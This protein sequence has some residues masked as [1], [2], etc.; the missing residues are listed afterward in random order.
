MTG[1]LINGEIWTERDAE[2][3]DDVKTQGE[4]GHLQAKERSLEQ[5]TPSPPSEGSK[6]A[7]ILTLDLQPPELGYY[8]SVV[9]GTQSGT[10]LWQ[11][12]RP[13][14]GGRSGMRSWAVAAA[15]RPATGG[16]RSHDY[17]GTGHPTRQGFKWSWPEKPSYSSA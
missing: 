5:V 2:M 9:Q 13:S 6:P 17:I 8:T 7:S 15:D 10:W 4:D 1:I 16:K 11:P 14:Q 3:G 12:S